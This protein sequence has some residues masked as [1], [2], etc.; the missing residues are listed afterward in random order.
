MFYD[1]FITKRIPLKY[2]QY[3]LE[4]LNKYIP[5]YISKSLIKK[6][7]TWTTTLNIK[8]ATNTEKYKDY[9]VFEIEN[10][11]SDEECDSIIKLAKHK[12]LI[13]STIINDHGKNI[14][15]L[16]TRK[17][18]QSW[19]EDSDNDIIKRLSIAVSKIT[20]IPV[21]HQEHLQVVSYEP[22]NYY[23][24]HFDA[25]YHPKILPIMNCGFGPR[26]YTLIIYLNNDFE[27]GETEFPK[28]GLKIKPE[29]GKAILFQNIDDNFDLI[30][31]SMHGGS[32]VTSGTK[33]I[34]NKWIRIWPIEMKHVL[35]HFQEN[36]NKNTIISPNNYKYLQTVLY[37]NILSNNFPLWVYDKNSFLFLEIENFINL[38]SL[39]NIDYVITNQ[40]SEVI[41]VPMDNPIDHFEKIKMVTNDNQ[42]PIIISPYITHHKQ[43]FFS[44][45][46]FVN[47]D[48]EGGSFYFPNIAKTIIPKKGKAIMFMSIDNSLSYDPRSLCIIEPVLKNKQIILEKHINV[49]PT[50]MKFILDDASNWINH[51]YETLK[52]KEI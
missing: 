44:I 4:F 45:Y 25:S 30:P 34:A 16:N 28:I 47:D 18:H 5:N 7:E 8:V 9:K 32:P 19:L 39:E 10:F 27:G 13:Q 17:S 12:G 31:E 40:L 20:N 50:N 41:T 1:Y 37:H 38:D 15:D 23:K 33:W 24:P 46:I 26:L 6:Y 22:S 35:S 43:R 29:K 2:V 48:Y 3:L 36:N 49:L 42:N 52:D 14:I 21:E 11:L 51:V